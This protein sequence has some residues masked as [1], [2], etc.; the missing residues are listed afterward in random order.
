MKKSYAKSLKEYDAPFELDSKKILAA[1]KRYK[2][3][4]KK[5]TSVALDETS[6]ADHADTFLETV[7]QDNAIAYTQERN[8]REWTFGYYLNNAAMRMGVIA[9]KRTLFREILQN[10]KILTEDLKWREVAGQE[11]AKVIWKIAYDA[12]NLAVE[13]AAVVLSASD[14]TGSITHAIPNPVC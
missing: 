7:I 6:M 2:D 12:L 5:P 13:N 1:M 3:S 4:R 9:E 11:D 8:S 10:N 14:I